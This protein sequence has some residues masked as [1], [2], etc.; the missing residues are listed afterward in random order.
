MSILIILKEL[1]VPLEDLSCMVGCNGI[2]TRW[3]DNAVFFK[4]IA[5]EYARSSGLRAYKER[6]ETGLLDI[7]AEL[8]TNQN[9][10]LESPVSRAGGI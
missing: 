10:C 5:F 3:R 7:R 9:T 6:I 1:N 4:G 2:S 8:S